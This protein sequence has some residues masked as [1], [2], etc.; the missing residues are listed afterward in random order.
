MDDFFGEEACDAF[1][2]GIK[3]DFSGLDG[4]EGDED[5]HGVAKA[6][7]ENDEILAK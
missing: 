2:S 6:L 3:I 1:V 7:I 5:K 4:V